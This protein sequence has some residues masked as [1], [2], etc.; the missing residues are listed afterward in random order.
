MMTPIIQIIC[1]VCH[2]FIQFLWTVTSKGRNIE[3]FFKTWT[4]IR[5]IPIVLFEILGFTQLLMLPYLRF[6]YTL[7]IPHV[8]EL[9]LLIAV[10]GTI[11][12]SWAKIVMGTSWGR[13]AQHDKSIQSR[14]I[15]TGPFSFTRNPIYVG[16]MMLFLGQQIALQSYGI[17]LML[18]FGLAVRHAVQTEEKLLRA[19]F[20]QKFVSYMKRVPKFL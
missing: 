7:E 8:K 12:A 13:P 14:L 18:F 15:T 11:L 4:R 17:A 19:H 20:G 16:L 3:S 2:I 9:G 5:S 1:L 6:P 10:L